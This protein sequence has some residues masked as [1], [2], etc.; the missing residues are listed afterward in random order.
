MHGT[1]RTA[2]ELLDMKPEEDLHEK[3]VQ[4]SWSSKEECDVGITQVVV[5]MCAQLNLFDST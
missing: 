2:A 5:M 4:F 3:V 1:E